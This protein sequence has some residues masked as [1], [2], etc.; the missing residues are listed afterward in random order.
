MNLTNFPSATTT[1]IAN[2]RFLP[3][4]QQHTSRLHVPDGELANRKGDCPFALFA[5]HFLSFSYKLLATSYKPFAI[6]ALAAIS[7]FY[8]SLSH[9]RRHSHKVGYI[10]LILVLHP[11]LLFFEYQTRR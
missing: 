1:N 7:V 10:L 6:V 4:R 5:F 2:H 11:S 8:S 9:S 3:Q